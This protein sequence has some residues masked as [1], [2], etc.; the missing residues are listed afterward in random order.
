MGNNCLF[1]SVAMG[2]WSRKG[3]AMRFILIAAALS[4][5][6]MLAVLNAVQAIPA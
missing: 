3:R 2:C 4:A 1:A 5:A 6:L